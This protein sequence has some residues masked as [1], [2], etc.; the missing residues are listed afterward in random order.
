MESKEIN[1]LRLGSW[2]HHTDYSSHRRI[3]KIETDAPLCLDNLIYVS[4][5]DIDP[6]PLTDDI[7]LK[8]GFKKKQSYFELISL[9]TL[10]LHNYGEK[11]FLCELVNDIKDLDRTV[12]LNTI[13]YLHQLQNLYFAITNK[14]LIYDTIPIFTI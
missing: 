12:Y 1:Q 11:G 13:K 4:I 9:T 2:V 3:T 10:R 5:K 6:I 14:E 7:L 8:A